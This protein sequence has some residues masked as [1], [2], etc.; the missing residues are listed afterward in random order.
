MRCLKSHAQIALALCVT[1]AVSACA[2]P[3]GRSGRGSGGSSNPSGVVNAPTAAAVAAPQSASAGDTTTKVVSAANAFL[4]T[5]DGA[6]RAKVQFAWDDSKQ[7]ANWSNFP[8]GIFQRAGLRMGDL[9]QAQRD[10]AMAILAATLSPRGYQQV[11]DQVEAD[12]VLK[13]TDGGSNLIFGADEYYISFLGEPSTSSPWMWQFGGHHLAVNATIVGERITLAPSLTG[14]QP[15]QFDK[16]GKTVRTIGA[17]SDAA[18]KLIASLSAEQQAKAIKSSA[19]V[20]LA[21]GPGKD[22]KVTEP[23][24]IT[25]ADLN[26]EQ[27][28]MLLDLIGARVGLLND[29]DASTQM[30]A[31]KSQIGKTYLAWYGPTTNGGAAYFRIQGPALI[32]EFSPQSMGGSAINHIHAMYRDPVNDYGAAWAVR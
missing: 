12:E 19:F 11:V 17:D 27:Q 4:A 2:N 31:I 10:A 18:F 6:G 22:G 9:S 23:E 25:G 20:D 21:L 1:C 13:Q 7:R 15:A 14:G 8:T 16:S 3:L 28:A 29:E 5:L 26:A 32:I 24:G 30:E